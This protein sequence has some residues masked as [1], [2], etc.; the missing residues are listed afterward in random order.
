MRFLVRNSAIDLASLPS[1]EQM[2]FWKGIV[3]VA[4]ISQQH[5]DGYITAVFS[6]ARGASR[7]LTHEDLWWR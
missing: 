5:Q 7:A 1:L 6:W 3:Q 2:G 4:V